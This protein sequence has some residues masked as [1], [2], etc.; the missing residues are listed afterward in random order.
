[1][2]DDIVEESESF[3]ISLKN[4]TDL[5]SRIH[6]NSGSLEV[7]ILDDDDGMLKISSGWDS[8]NLSE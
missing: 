1:M 4:T 8:V 6:L 3:M 7:T 5:D 2:D